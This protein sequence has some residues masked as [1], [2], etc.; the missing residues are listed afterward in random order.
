MRRKSFFDLFE[1]V[2]KCSLAISILA[3]TLSLINECS[4]KL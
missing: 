4:T 1:F 3:L 2:L